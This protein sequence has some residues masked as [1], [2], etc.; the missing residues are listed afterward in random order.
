MPAQ[1]RTL[2][3]LAW[4]F[5]ISLILIGTATSFTLLFTRFKL[6]DAPA[7]V[8]LICPVR[9]P[10]EQTAR[11]DLVIIGRVFAV[12]PG[13]TGGDVLITVDRALKG[14]APLVG[15]TI[16]ALDVAQPKERPGQLAGELHFASEQPPYLL[17][18]RARSD[19]RYNTSRCDGSRFLG[20]GLTTEENQALGS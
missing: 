4:I 14:N 15:V 12:L 2:G 8:A 17:F 18:L 13:P 10:D 9:S 6:A 16:A 1:H 20:R 5:F 19:G 3:A 11:A 7:R